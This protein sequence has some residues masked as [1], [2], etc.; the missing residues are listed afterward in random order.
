MTHKIIHTADVQVKCRNEVQRKFT[1]KCLRNIEEALIKTGASIYVISGDCFEFGNRKNK[2][3]DSER[4]VF[5]QHI[6]NVTEIDTVKEIVII[7]GNHDYVTTKFEEDFFKSLEFVKLINSTGKIKYFDKSGRYQSSIND[8]VYTIYAIT[9]SYQTHQELLNSEPV[10]QD[11]INIVLWHGMLQEYVK[12]SGLPI[13]E[14]KI[15][16][17]YSMDNFDKNSIIMAG[18]IHVPYTKK[19]VE[20]NSIFCYPS[21]PL[22]HTFGEGWTISIDSKH[23]RAKPGKEHSVVYWE[24][25]N[26]L[27]TKIKTAGIYKE[28]PINTVRHITVEL[29]P[30]AHVDSLL[31]GFEYMIR[32]Q[33]E[34]EGLGK[35]IEHFNFKLK[36]STKFLE[37]ESKFYEVLNKHLPKRNYELICDYDKKGNIDEYQVSD[38]PVIQGIVEN[39]LQELDNEIADEDGPKEVSLSKDNLDRLLLKNE[40]IQAIFDKI[41]E[42]NLTRSKIESE[43]IEDVRKQISEIFTTELN[44]DQRDNV[45]YKIELDKIGTNNF[46]LLGENI[47]DLRTKGTTRILGTNDIGKTTLY[48][49]VRFVVTGD[50][51]EGLAKNQSNKNALLCFNKFRP[52]IKFVEVFMEMRINSHPVTIKRRL[53]L[54]SDT[55]VDKQLA[56]INHDM[57]KVYEQEQAQKYLD[58]WFGDTLDNIA[59]INS[60]KLEKL[61]KSPSKELNNL[62][63]KYLGVE[64]LDK[65]E[66]GLDGIKTLLARTKPTNTKEQVQEAIDNVRTEIESKANILAQIEDE[67][68]PT[69]KEQH[70][71]LE[72]DLE[73]HNTRLQ[74]FGNVPELIKK[75]DV[76]IETT[77]RLINNFEILGLGELKDLSELVE[78][79]QPN[80]DELQTKIETSKSELEGINN[81]IKTEI[82]DIRSGFDNALDSAKEDCEVYK[83]GLVAIHEALI[84]KVNEQHKIINTKLENAHE[85]IEEVLERKTKAQAKIEEIEG[86]IALFESGFCPTC[87]QPVD[88]LCH[89]EGEETLTEYKEDLNKLLELE[90][91]VRDIIAN[92]KHDINIISGVTK[93]TFEQVPELINYLNNNLKD[94][95]ETL[96]ETD[97]NDYTKLIQGLGEKKV[98]IHEL[99]VV[100]QR[101]NSGDSSSWFDL[102]NIEYPDTVEKFAEL[103]KQRIDI[104]N[105]FDRYQQEYETIKT[106]FE[107]KKEEYLTKKQEYLDY[108]QRIQET[109]KEVEEHNQKLKTY[110]SDMERL[111]KE[112]AGLEESLPRYN[113]ILDDK[114]VVKDELSKVT[115]SLN[116]ALTNVSGINSEIARFEAKIESL[117]KEYRAVIEYHV[118][119]VVWKLYNK[120]IKKDF[121][122]AIFD[123]YRTFLN[124]TLNHL[125]SGVNFK[126]IWDNNLD[127]VFNNIKSGVGSDIKVQSA[128]GMVTSFM[129]LSLIY[130]L[131]ILNTRNDISHIFIDELSGAFNDG[132][133]LSY[134]ANNYHDLFVKMLHKF[135]DKSI[136]I[137][138]HHIENLEEVRSFEVVLDNDTKSSKF[139]LVSAR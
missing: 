125:L 2:V 19:S 17:L 13:P 98:R 130:T 69:L 4:I 72:T 11:K 28:S 91:R 50:A 33:C 138:D 132:S 99:N 70:S 66:E 136:F 30:E 35:N 96:N 95:F 40:D 36:M 79:T 87:K 135:N 113:E 74:N 27:P 20:R 21:S 124:R 39:K 127:L 57:D 18:D 53:E 126:L 58:T 49:M 103:T 51:F 128:S 65:L 60:T 107:T 37:D 43:Y 85:K 134:Q 110:H 102:L 75:V 106:E 118:T 34:P 86:N 68:I 62:I 46:M 10:P 120:I 122:T 81:K 114:M 92:R 16:E 104:K 71:K 80:Y 14:N 94:K 133:N 117:E 123:Y 76:Q 64:Y 129:G 119:N 84:N 67:E 26:S 89:V 139:E 100:I 24:L 48:N 116:M 88:K 47:I 55:Q 137:V 5:F 12:D 8:I 82:A 61:L 121:K 41:V 90:A 63:L 59:I 111:Q 23:N 7:D 54:V 6:K 56:V 109:N 15:S 115:E 131:H 52:D 29:D 44:K 22:E 105:T 83:N 101:M 77:S 78:P 9:D 25:D 3:S 112:K 38:D 31:L 45:H 73:T 1:E 97:I 108:N 93:Y 42:E 32:H